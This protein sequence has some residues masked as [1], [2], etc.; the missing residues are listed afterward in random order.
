MSA[1]K[2]K[3]KKAG[4]RE[5]VPNSSGLSE[6]TNSPRGE[7]TGRNYTKKGGA[8]SL[9]KGG[10]VKLSVRGGGKTPRGSLE[11]MILRKKLQ[12]RGKSLRNLWKS[13]RQLQEGRSVGDRSN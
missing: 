12:N 5:E 4:G 6:E 10:K 1:G 3:E 8:E 9:K 13:M 2:E 11:T 7:K